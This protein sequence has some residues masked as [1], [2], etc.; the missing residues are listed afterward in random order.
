MTDDVEVAELTI[1]RA[2]G[3]D[4]EAVREVA[5]AAWQD[6]YEA[7]DEAEVES[8]VDGWYAPADLEE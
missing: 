7:F 3:N 4:L 8:I 5:K 2:N 1:R 6:T